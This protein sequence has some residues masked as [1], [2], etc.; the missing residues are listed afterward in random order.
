MEV[1]IERTEPAWKGRPMIDEIRRL[2]LACIAEAKDT[3]YLEN[4]YFT[5]PL[6]TEALATRLADAP[7]A[8][9]L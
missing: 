5:S 8:F 2:N 9:A 6:V 4:Q 3:I 7:A 1:A